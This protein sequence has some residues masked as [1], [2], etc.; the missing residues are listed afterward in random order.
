MKILQANIADNSVDLC[1]LDLPYN[2]TAC[3]FDKTK[4]DLQKLWT[5]LLR[6]GHNK[7]TYVFFCSTKFGYKLIQSQISLFRYDLV[8]SKSRPTGFYHANNQPLR[9]HEMIYVFYKQKGTYN[10]QKTPGKPYHKAASNSRT[11]LYQGQS[12]LLATNNESGD[13]YP[14][15]ILEFS[16]GNY[17]SKHPTAKPVDLM[18]YIVNTYTNKNDSVLDCFFGSGSSLKACNALYRNYIGIELHKPYFDE[19][20]KWY[21]TSRI[22]WID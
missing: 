14:R 18:R 17:Q 1:I 13:R 5:E 6:V 12:P 16:N 2:Q 19:V 22:H 21:N 4:I 8:Y 11:E 9:S 10:P 20:H 3:S 15:S 7:T